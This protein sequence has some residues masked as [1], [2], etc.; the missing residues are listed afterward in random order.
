MIKIDNSLLDYSKPIGVG[1]S[2]GLDS[3]VLSH[4]LFMG[5]RDLIFIHVNHKTPYSQLA[6]DGF[7]HYTDFLI[8]EKEKHFQTK[9]TFTKFVS[10]K[11]EKIDTSGFLEADFREYRYNLFDQI[12]GDSMNDQLVI[13]HHLGDA[14]ESYLL[15]CLSSPNRKLL[16][17]VTQRNNYKIIR[18]FLKTRKKCIQA[19]A[20]KHDLLKWVVEDPSNNDTKF[21][22]NWIRH[23]LIPVIKTK[24]PGLEKT[25]LKML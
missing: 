25:V 24:Y 5:G 22:R 19:Y 2:M 14:V 21:R 6:D 12:F 20:E 10:A 3:V 9:T 7:H 23:F 17:A 18:P 8:K 4:F 15:N 1:L 16:P 13:C 11:N